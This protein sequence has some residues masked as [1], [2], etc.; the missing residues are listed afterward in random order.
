M[1]MLYEMRHYGKVLLKMMFDVRR[2]SF[3][4]GRMAYRAL[5]LTAALCGFGNY[6]KMVGQRSS[7]S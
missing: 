1:G 6:K 5:P 3:K 2:S 7:N 4:I